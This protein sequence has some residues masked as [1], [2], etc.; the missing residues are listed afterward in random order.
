[1]HQISIGAWRRKARRRFSES[2]QGGKID[3]TLSRL[4]RIDPARQAQSARRVGDGYRIQV[5]GGADLAI[6]FA[7]KFLMSFSGTFGLAACT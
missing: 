1:M 6:S 5:L 7:Q 3:R 4:I 2:S